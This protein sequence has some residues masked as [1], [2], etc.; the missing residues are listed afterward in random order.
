MQ[1]RIDQLKSQTDAL[2]N[3]LG[4][5]HRRKR[6]YAG[7]FSTPDAIYRLHR[8]EVMQRRE[9]IAPGTPALIGSPVSLPADA[10]DAER[11]LALA[12]WLGSDPTIR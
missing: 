3:R 11:R 1:A 10:P 7:L 4:T 5:L 2:T 9:E 12:D 8:G 6:C